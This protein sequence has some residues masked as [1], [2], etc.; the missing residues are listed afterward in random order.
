M[1]IFS[2]LKD[3][4]SHFIILIF[5]MNSWN[6]EYILVEIYAYSLQILSIRKMMRF[7][8]GNGRNKI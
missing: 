1:K 3:L 6:L 7:T 8:I 2:R 4:N 5:L